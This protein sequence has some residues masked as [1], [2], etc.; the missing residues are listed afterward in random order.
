M[1]LNERE[2]RDKERREDADKY[3]GVFNTVYLLGLSGHA[4]KF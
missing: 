3:N 4:V 2:E 1:W